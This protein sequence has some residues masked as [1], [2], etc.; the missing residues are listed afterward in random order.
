MNII[1]IQ[2]RIKEQLDEISK[3]S[4]NILDGSVSK[5]RGEMILE[6]AQA[7]L[8]YFRSEEIKSVANKSI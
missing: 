6:T 2:K 1:F 7:Q 8:D 3:I 5:E 4:S